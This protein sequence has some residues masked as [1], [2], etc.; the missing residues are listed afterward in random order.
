MK[1]DGG[2]VT[3]MSLRDYFAAHAPTQRWNTYLPTMREKPTRPDHQPVGNNGEWP[4]DAE[5][6]SLENWRH[7]PCWDATEE[8]PQFSYWAKAWEDFWTATTEWER[9]YERE[10]ERQWPYFYAD[11]MLERRQ[12]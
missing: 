5:A 8:F 9:D 7:D 6:K 1:N 10:A 2:Q 3:A 12:K 11:A 4:T